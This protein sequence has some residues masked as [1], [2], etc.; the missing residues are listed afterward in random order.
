RDIWAL[1]ISDN[2]ATDEDEPEVL[3]ECGM[4]ARE[5]ITVEMCLYMV[6]LLTANYGQPGATGDRV[7]NIV[8]TREIWIIPTLNPDG[9]EYNISD[10][11]FHN[12]RKNRQP[13][14]GSS[15]VG[16]D[17]NR[18]FSFM[19][20]CCGGSSD[21]PG[22]GTYRGRYA[23]EAVEARVLRDFVLSR[24]VNG[25]QQLRSVL[26]WHAYGARIYW[27]Y[28]YTKTDVPSTMTVDDHEAFVALGHN[29]AALNDYVA[30]QGSDSYIYD[31]DFPAW[32]YGNQRVFVFT[33][34]MYPPFGCNGC[35]GFKPP[36]ELIERE[37][38]RNRT[39]VLYLL[40][41]SDCPWRSA[42][43]GWSNC[44]PLYDDFEVGRG[45]RINPYGTDTATRGAFARGIPQSSSDASGVKQRAGAASGRMAMATG[46][47]RGL[48]AAAND[49]DGGT[50]SAQSPALNL[51]TGA[52]TLRFAYSFGHNTAAT[53]A[54]GVRF[55]VRD[56][57][58]LVTPVWTTTATAGVNRN[59]VW[60][61][62]SVPVDAWA[63]QAI[64]LLVEATD[65]DADSLIE[66]AIDDVRVFR[67][68]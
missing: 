6:R 44:G 10:G 36:D 37:T 64:T 52:W 57:T 62:V 21:K 56:S 24:R 27:P 7:T 12:W 17:L 39:A 47:T 4:H 34:E 18:N 51:D 5:H 8:N 14:P 66:V 19:W 33:F 50:T 32:G 49:L 53:K 38:T 65:S 13:N 28:G 67:T 45:W 1:K 59:A 54:D 2:V 23:F 25:R 20:G 43:L 22:S 46:L 16:I 26:N 55:S 48:S 68:P 3:A 41:Q 29:M 40:E 63:G 30:H 58:G 35:G 11:V 31:G 42:G 15:A 61:T 9:A 60:Q